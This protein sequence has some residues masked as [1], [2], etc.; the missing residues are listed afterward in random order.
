MLLQFALDIFCNRPNG[1][2]L[3]LAV[4]LGGHHLIQ[5]RQLRYVMGIPQVNQADTFRV[6]QEKVVQRTLNGRQMHPTARQV[7]LLGISRHLQ[8]TRLEVEPPAPPVHQVAPHQIHEA[9]AVHNDFGI[10]MARLDAA[11]DAL[12]A[13]RTGICRPHL[14][15]DV[16]LFHTE[17]HDASARLQMSLPFELRQRVVHAPHD[18]VAGQK[19]RDWKAK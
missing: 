1:N 11:P 8:T 5:P 6:L 7:E 4:A 9:E 3:L 19:K 15:A 18:G 10:E 17:V 13:F 12:H 14:Q 2:R 16:L